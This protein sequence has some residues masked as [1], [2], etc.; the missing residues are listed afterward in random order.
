MSDAPQIQPPGWYYAQGD[1]PGTQRYWDGSSWQGGPQPVPGAEGAVADSAGGSL[2]DPGKRIVA[3]LIDGIIWFVIS[4]VFSLV[5]AGG[6][7]FAGDQP[8]F[9]RGAIASL[10]GGAVVVAYEAFMV[11]TRGATAGKMALGMKVVNEDGSAADLNT[12]LR[13]MFLYIGFIF[14]GMIPILGGLL[15]LIVAI[16]G[17]VFLFTDDKNQTPWDKIG[18]TLVVET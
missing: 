17:L 10:I 14:I 18:K 9:L 15:F 7:A 3:R 4:L 12:G 1:P 5:I 11:G 2:A 13:R 6:S 8:S 16:V